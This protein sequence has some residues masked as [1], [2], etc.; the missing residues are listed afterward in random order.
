MMEHHKVHTT[1]QALQA[2]RKRLLTELAELEAEIKVSSE[3]K[4]S[5]NISLSPSLLAEIEEIE[6]EEKT[7]KERRINHSV[8]LSPSFMAKVDEYM[9][10]KGF[11]NRSLLFEKA[12]EFYML[13]HP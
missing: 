9:K 8:L 11:S 7:S 1:V 6:Y 2:K 12:L 4:S 3:R 10:E 5:F 13:K